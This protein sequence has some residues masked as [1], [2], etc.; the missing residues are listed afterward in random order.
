[1]A[2]IEVEHL[3]KW[4]GGTLAVDDISFSVQKGEIV[5]FLGR[6][7][8][9]KTT[10]MRIL[11]GSLGATEGRALIG[12]VD[13]SKDPQAVKRIVGYLPEFPPLY[14]DMTVRQYLTFCANLKRASNVSTSVERVIQETSLG[15]VAHRVIDHLSKGYRQ[16]VGLAQALVHEP[17]VLSLDEPMSGLD[18]QQRQEI[19]DFIKG[20]A[21]RGVTVVLSTHV[22]A[23]VETV[24]DRVVIIEKGK[25]LAQ[26]SLEKLADAGRGIVMQVA[27][28]EPELFDRLAQIPGVVGAFEREDEVVVR[29]DR[30]VREEVARVAVDFGLLAMRAEQGLQDVFLR[31]T[32]GD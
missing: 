7:G 31:L 23:E 13:V 12:D 27:R 26:D 16:R 9:G 29:A 3:S 1:M 21:Q 5:G 30:E 20:L 10:T 25:I 24:C 18:P 32:R 17:K 22:L 4:Y 6:N 2:T 8:A 15:T 19:L 28:M 11:T 14:V